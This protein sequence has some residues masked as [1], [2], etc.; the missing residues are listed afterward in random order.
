MRNAR[1]SVSDND[2]LKYQI[3]ANTLKEQRGFGSQDFK[4]PQQQGENRSGAQDNRGAGEGG[5][6]ALYN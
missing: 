2:V 1:R 6:D 5:D 3:F 4:F